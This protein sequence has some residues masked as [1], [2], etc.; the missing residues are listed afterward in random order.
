MVAFNWKRVNQYHFY[1]GKLI[2]QLNIR[3]FDATNYLVRMPEIIRTS[4]SLKEKYFMQYLRKMDCAMFLCDGRNKILLYYD[5]KDGNSA[6]FKRGSSLTGK[7]IMR[8]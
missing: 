6:L 2:K 4:Y 5:L 3:V 1:R 7:Q 8:Q